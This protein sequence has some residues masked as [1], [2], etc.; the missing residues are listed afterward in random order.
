VDQ[1]EVRGLHPFPATRCRHAGSGPGNALV[2]PRKTRLTCDLDLAVCDENCSQL[3]WQCA[4]FSPSEEASRLESTDRS[5]G[6]PGISTCR[7]S[8]GAKS[9]EAA[10]KVEGAIRCSSITGSG[11]LARDAIAPAGSPSVE[12]RRLK[13]CGSV[14]GSAV[15]VGT[16]GMGAAKSSAGVAPTPPRSACVCGS[17]SA[18][19]R[20]VPSA[21]TNLPGPTR[22]HETDGRS[23]AASATDLPVLRART[24]PRHCLTAPAPRGLGVEL[25]RSS[26]NSVGADS[27]T[28]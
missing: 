10:P 13:F 22:I 23:E 3:E 26:V 27:A 5:P 9:M 19:G 14:A 17:T 6:E 15:S 8:F 24:R 25:V 12:C 20:V 16:S 7:P 2:N 1:T 4:T 21:R 11:A 18:I 28:G